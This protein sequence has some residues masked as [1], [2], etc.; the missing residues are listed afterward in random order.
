MEVRAADRTL[1]NDQRNSRWNVVG[2]EQPRGG[3]NAYSTGVV[4][5][6]QGGSTT[7]STVVQQSA[8]PSWDQHTGAGGGGGGPPGSVGA[9]GGATSVVPPAPHAV[10]G[11]SS[12]G[13]GGTTTSGGPE[14]FAPPKGGSPGGAT[15]QDTIHAPPGPQDTINPFTNTAAVPP[16]RSGIDDLFEDLLRAPDAGLRGPPPPVAQTAGQGG[17]HAQQTP[18]G[19][20]GQQATAGVVHHPA[21]QTAVVQ[22]AGVRAVGTGV[23]IESVRAREQQ[24][25]DRWD[26]TS[27][28]STV[29]TSHDTP[30][31]DDRAD[32]T[33]ERNSLF[34]STGAVEGSAP[35]AGAF[36]NE[37]LSS[38]PS[39]DPMV[40]PDSPTFSGDDVQEAKGRGP[41][42][43]YAAFG[44]RREGGPTSSSAAAPP[45][46]LGGGVERIAGRGPPGG[47]NAGAGPPP[48]TSSAPQSEQESSRPSAAQASTDDQPVGE[49]PIK[50]STSDMQQQPD[51]KVSSS[52][53]SDMLM[54][55]SG[56]DEGAGPFPG[57]HQA[58]PSTEG[59]HFHAWA[60]SS[61][62]SQ[63]LAQYPHPRTSISCT[64]TATQIVSSGAPLLGGP[65]AP[66]LLPPPSAGAVCPP[67]LSGQSG[68]PPRP[69]A[70]APVGLGGPA[71]VGLGPPTAPVGLGGPPASVGAPTTPAP[72]PKL[73]V[74]PA[75]SSTLVVPKPAPLTTTAGPTSAPPESSDAESESSK[76]KEDERARKRAETERERR[77][78]KEE[79]ERREALDAASA[80]S[81]VMAE[82]LESLTAPT[83]L[84]G[85]SGEG[86][87][88]KPSPPKK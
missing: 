44:Q 56:P 37:P 88:S 66:Q 42:H 9:A 55:Q 76:A 54:Q 26:G 85:T 84:V 83:A 61:T 79:R 41:P 27:A 67:A 24:P 81:S 70:A 23:P 38:V 31:T 63:E 51:M 25:H 21:Q 49:N 58:P 35:V 78:K 3:Y 74:K 45:S 13:T 86:A 18:A 68:Q 40:V 15:Q 11:G 75:S 47:T 16:S 57:G 17:Q 30:K 72:L 46:Y 65:S 20:G 10:A 34:N 60:S 32:V 4:F 7:T 62:S 39:V 50:A 64:N 53:S 80:M 2:E 73:L 5:D 28:T 48:P 22:Q 43:P 69:P 33:F 14:R 52:T 29:A 71:P 59:A 77:K 36:S 8:A 87:S 6:Q 19:Q 82:S 12:V 1:T